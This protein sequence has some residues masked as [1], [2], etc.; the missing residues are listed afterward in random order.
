[1]YKSNAN[2]KKYKLLNMKKTIENYE[3]GE[4]TVGQGDYQTIKSELDRIDRMYET[5]EKK[6]S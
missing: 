4:K 2:S 3:N 1:M 6:A 5:Q